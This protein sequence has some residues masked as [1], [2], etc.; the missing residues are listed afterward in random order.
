MRIIDRQRMAVIPEEVPVR[1]DRARG[2]AGQLEL[3]AILRGA[4]PRP[5]AQFVVRVICR[6]IVLEARSMADAKAHANW[7]R[8]ISH[9]VLSLTQRADLPARFAR[10]GAPLVC[11]SH[12]RGDR[13]RSAWY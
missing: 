10:G 3:E 5:Q 8:V 2:S 13:T 4:I 11:A 6:A 12:T 1:C 7:P 9:N